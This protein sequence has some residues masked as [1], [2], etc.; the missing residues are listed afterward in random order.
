LN[1]IFGKEE[2]FRN[3]GH[4]SQPSRNERVRFYLLLREW[5]LEKATLPEK[6]M[7]HSSLQKRGQSGRI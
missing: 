2:M 7:V 1:T 6:R 3:T 5:S 4:L